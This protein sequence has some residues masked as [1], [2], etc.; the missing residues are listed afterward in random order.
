MQS[1]RAVLQPCR[2]VFGETGE[3]RERERESDGEVAQSEGV[4]ARA[5][6]RVSFACNSAGESPAVSGYLTKQQQSTQC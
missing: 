4:R 1:F 5:R 3:T 6:A 2:G